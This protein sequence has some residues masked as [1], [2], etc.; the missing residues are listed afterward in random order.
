[1]R[2]VLSPTLAWLVA[3]ALPASAEEP[4]P[5]PAPARG[6]ANEALLR[7]GEAAPAPAPAAK[8]VITPPKLL[9]D[10]G[11]SYPAEAL[12]AGFYEAVTVQL[13]VDV[14]AEG[15]VTKVEVEQGS[16]APGFEAAAVAAAMQLTYEPAKKGERAIAS[17]WRHVYA[18]EVP[19]ARLEGTVRTANTDRALPN[20]TVR[21]ERE[22]Q[23]PLL[24]VT[25]GEGRFDFGA[26][27]RGA[28]R[29]VAALAGFVDLG[30]DETLVPAQ[31]TT[32]TLRLERVPAEA[33]KA[34]EG[35]GLRFEE[36]TVRGTKPP[37]EVTKRTLEKRELERVPGTNGDALRALQ[38]LPGVARPPGL[39][40]LLIVRGAAPNSTNVFVDGTLIPLVYHFG[41]LSSVVPTEL[42]ERIDFYP[43]NFSARYGR[44][45]GGIVDVGLRA[46]RKDTVSGMAQVDLIDARGVVE[47]PIGD[48]GWTFA[49]AGRRS[50]VDAWLKPVLE[51]AGTGV[52]TA[53]VYYDWQAIVERPMPDK[54]RLN[55][56][57]YGSDDRL[58][59]LI[60]SVAGSNPAIGGGLGLRTAFW[61]MAAT[62]KQPL[63]PKTELSMVHA[64][65]KNTIEFNLGDNAFQLDGLPL[66][67][68]V[69][70]THRLSASTTLDVGLDML[71]QPYDIYVRL[72]PPPRPGEPTDGPGLSR[73]PRTAR[74]SAELYRPAAFAELAI[75]PSPGTRIVPGVR[76]DYARD[77]KSWDVSP[78]F[79]ARHEIAS[80]YPKTVVKGGAGMFMQ[81]PQPQETNAVFGI[82]GVTS[83]RSYAYSVG[84]EQDVAPRVNASLEGFYRRVDNIVVQRLMNSGV[85]AAYGLELLVRY[86]PDDKFFGWLAYTLSR[87]AQQDQPSEPERLAQFDQTHILTALGS[88]RL[89]GGWELGGRFRLVSGSM[90]T[91]NTYGFFDG[92]SG[93]NLPAQGYPPF[94]ERLPLFHQLDI[95]LDRTWTFATHKIGAY[96]DLLNAY[97]SPNADGV[98]YNYN[99]TRSTYASSLPILPSIG[100]RIDF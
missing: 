32:L 86:K 63:G 44:V 3:A 93:V 54:G 6:G 70:L 80:E 42:I 35:S 5:A 37:R 23:D 39:A 57:F 46:P 67:N 65:G 40:G 74:E 60:K 12:A 21:L 36:V 47:G 96:L 26:Q 49:L 98:S 19:K 31:E 56:A 82:P 59:L 87:S 89:G 92:N 88:W 72:P 99:F 71:W 45:T 83:N 9:A 48:T 43:G 29:V 91:P 76:L 14:D 41:G 17:R 68:R 4:A 61:R 30:V 62:Y 55:L 85:G 66:T 51:A 58:E 50:Y 75:T 78:R 22:G 10:P 25:D 24:T 53:P 28:V 90:T 79:S 11:V 33:P 27:P 16:K 52:S 13:K 73:E 97:N 94:G 8:L 34:P 7:P 77:T 95:R 81:P 15:K 1:M 20:V 64:V 100:A 18:F 2:R 69:D 38:S 84:V